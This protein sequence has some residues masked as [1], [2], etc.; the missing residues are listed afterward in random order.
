MARKLMDKRD[1]LINA[2]K[3]L[4]YKQGFNIV[5]ADEFSGV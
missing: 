4:I 1:A 5:S 2:A 3:D